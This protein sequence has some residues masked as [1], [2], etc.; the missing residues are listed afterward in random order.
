MGNCFNKRNAPKV[1]CGNFCE[2]PNPSNG[3]NDSCEI[4]YV[5]FYSKSLECTLTSFPFTPFTPFAP[6]NPVNS[7]PTSCI[8]ACL[9]STRDEPALRFA[10]RQAMDKKWDGKPPKMR[11]V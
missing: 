6:H 4:V 3:K 10:V 8:Y 9:T 2:N 1:S 11:K 7:T 5:S